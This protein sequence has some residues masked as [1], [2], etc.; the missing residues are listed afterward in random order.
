MA[1]LKEDA[2]RAI[3]EVIASAFDS[4]S[5]SFLGL[6]PAED[7][8]T[9]LKFKTNKNNLISLFVQAMGGN[10]PNKI[11]EDALKYLLKV[12]SDYIDVVKLR[13]QARIIQQ[14]NS[15]LLLK[16]NI[17]SEELDRILNENLH[18]SSNDLKTI[19]NSES[20]SAKNIATALQIIQ[21]NKSK[22]VERPIVFF[23][24]TYDERTA[25]QP[26]KNLHLI[27][28]TKIPRLW[29]L[30][31]LSS[32]Y[33]K[34]GMRVPSIHGG[35]PNCLTEDQL[36]KTVEGFKSAKELYLLGRPV[37]L[38]VDGRAVSNSCF[39]RN[40][41]DDNRLIQGSLV[42]YT[43]KRECLMIRTT[44]KTIIKVSVDHE[45]IVLD[46]ES[47][48]YRRKAA[49]EI[50]EGDIL[51]KEN[52]SETQVEKII[53]I[54]QHNTYCITEAITNS[55]NVN[56]I[57]TGNCRCFL[58][59]LFSNYGFTDDGKIEYKNEDFNALEEQRSKYKLD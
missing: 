25:E 37:V 55:I 10:K 5:L 48:S 56:G 47:N 21:V 59:T 34:K 6:E 57:T 27:P 8:D 7:K 36:I 16:D 58:T 52:N 4:I 20:K 35:H 24:V 54:G 41:N 26:E 18:R 43:G 53:A 1:S 19:F 12:G 23:N 28:G 33:W 30:D 42:Y 32:D 13:T 2:I 39:L 9:K 49:K 3:Q 46:K 29:Y 51:P 45:M 44:C 11:E 17:D 14:V 15:N 31:E 50:K 40:T 22:G 38:E